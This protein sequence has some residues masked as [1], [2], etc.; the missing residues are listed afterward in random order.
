M[1]HLITL[2]KK[3]HGR[4]PVVDLTAADLEQ[5]RA[6]YLPTNRTKVEGSIRLA[7]VRFCE[8]RQDLSHLV[9]NHVPTTTIP[10]A[11]VEACRRAKA[12]VGAHRGGA[13]RNRHESAFVPGTMRRHWEMNRRLWAGEQVSVDDATRNI[14]IWIPWPWGGCPCSDKFGVR[15]GR[16]QTLIVHDDASSFVPFVSSVFRWQQSYRATDAASC[17]YRAEREIA[18]FDRWV[19]EGGVWQAKRT[20]EILGGRFYSAKGRPNQKLVE[21]F[22]GRLWNIMAGELGDVGRYQ[23][24]MAT[25]SKLYVDARQGRVDPRNHFLSLSQ[26]QAALYRGIQYLNER[27][28]ESKEYGKWI[29][30]ER[31]EADLKESPREARAESDFLIMPVAKVLTVSNDMVSTTEDGPHGM[32]MVWRFTAPWL[33]EFRGRRV[34]LYFDPQS[35]WPVQG[36]IT[37]ENSRKPLGVVECANPLGISRDREA[38]MVKAVRQTV[39][40]ETR[41][42]SRI[43][44]DRINRELRH[45]SGVAITTT[46]PAA[47]PHPDPETAERIAAA[48]PAIDRAGIQVDIPS[49]PASEPNPFLDLTSRGDRGHPAAPPRVT[50]EDLAASRSRKLAT[51]RGEDS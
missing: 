50:R 40:T 15:L 37:L 6:F 49:T 21:N 25:E 1:K 35:D 22:I 38:E 45:P 51:L 41:V 24:E 13:R 8:S 46:A 14:P 10:T 4:P 42:L 7:W 33:A 2:G 34:C 32:P 27:R 5:I 3:A 20:L 11:V 9:S 17:I 48:T 18:C 28:L 47:H 43:H 36:T 30:Q 12:H 23:A 39:L 16:W 19:I 31:W 29:P 26:G 44:Q